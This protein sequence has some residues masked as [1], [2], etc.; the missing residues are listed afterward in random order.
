[1]FVFV[2]I[3]FAVK[4]TSPE[5]FIPILHDIQRQLETLVVVTH[6]Q[7]FKREFSKSFQGQ[8]KQKSEMELI[9][10]YLLRED[11]TQTSP[12]KSGLEETK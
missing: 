9:V 2:G 6:Y 11:E 8:E 1:M 12:E 10:E 7:T 4:T 3:V 5:D